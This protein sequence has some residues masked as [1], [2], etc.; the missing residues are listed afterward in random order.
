M[1]NFPKR[2]NYTERKP[3]ESKPREKVK[4]YNT[5]EWQKLRLSLLMDEPLC[6]KCKVRAASVI[7]HIKPVR[8]GGEFWDLENLQPLCKWC[9]NSKSGKE[10]NLTGKGGQNPGGNVL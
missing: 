4:D 3:F 10:N 9:H 1:P 5:R 8:M 7:D 2:K 6:R